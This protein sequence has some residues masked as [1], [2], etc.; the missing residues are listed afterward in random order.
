M[1]T[2]IK[3]LAN[4]IK[5][6]KIN[7][8]F[9]RAFQDAEVQEFV[10]AA[11]QGQLYD[12]GIYSNGKIIKTYAAFQGNVYSR[13]TLKIKSEKGQPT[14]RV[15]LYDTGDFYDSW[16][17]FAKK[18]QAVINYDK[19]KLKLISENVPDVMD[20]FGLTETNFDRLTWNV[21]YPFVMKLL[22]DEI[23]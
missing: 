21:I 7:D 12:D 13:K 18:T 2:K 3:I 16:K 15:T 20:I 14:D 8:L 6:I 22:K 10:I 19:K 17:M 9:Y 1:D 23:I 4:K 11:N 5:S